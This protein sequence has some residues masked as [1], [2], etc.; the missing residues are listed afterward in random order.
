[1]QPV[2]KT[3][4]LVFNEGYSCSTGQNLIRN[5]LISIAIHLTKQLA[6]L[7]S[8]PEV[9]GL[10]AL[11]QI[12]QAR[13]TTRSTPDGDI[14][15]L[16]DQDRSQWDAELIESSGNLVSAALRSGRHGTYTLQAAIAA[17]HAEAPTYADTDWTEIVGLY[18]LLIRIEPSPVAQLNRAVAVAMRD[19]SAAGISMIDELF[20]QGH[21]IDYHFA[22]AARGELHKRNGNRSGARADFETALKLARQE[23]EKRL[24]Y[25]R[26][27]ELA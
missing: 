9:L 19:S 5:E 18:E 1:M 2:L 13:A 11:M 17:L 7:L 27:R 12:H 20:A 4:Y 26:L 23:P 22:Y 10:L 24:M 21:L 6:E 3:I 16:E 25:A 15:L 8:E 14:I